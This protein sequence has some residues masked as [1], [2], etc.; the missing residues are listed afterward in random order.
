MALFKFEGDF[1]SLSEPQLK[2]VESVLQKHG[3]K[4]GKVIVEPVGKKG[5]NYIANVKRFIHESDGATFKMIGKSAPSAE[6]LRKMM[7]TDVLFNNEITMYQEVIP[8]FINLQDVAGIP[9]GERV[10]FP[11]C[12]GVLNE[13]PSELILLEDLSDS[14]F[15]MLNRFEPL[16]N[17]TVRLVVKDLAIF[18]S[19][20]YALKELQP[21]TYKNLAGKLINMWALLEH[22][23]ETQMFFEGTE[24]DLK[25]LMDSEKYKKILSGS[26]SDIKTHVKKVYNYEKSSK[27]TVIQQGDCW[28]NNIM[29]KL[30]V[31]HFTKTVVPQYK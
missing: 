11:V 24:N 3:F 28:S 13:A 27:Y 14:S 18:H 25:A 2:L 22:D 4:E 15:E 10:R 26:L 20:S 23:V 19:L 5:D 31:R 6:I 29:F 16:S 8:K 12:Y 7:K 9:A 21:E 1:E 30:E 17:E